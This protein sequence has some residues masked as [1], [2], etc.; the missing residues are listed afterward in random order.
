MLLLSA[1]VFG[2]FERVPT[3]AAVVDDPYLFSVFEKW[4][5]D[6]GRVYGSLNEKLQRFGVFKDNFHFIE[7]MK[8]Q[9]GLAYTVGLSKFA[10]L[11]NK[12]FLQRCATYRTP[13]ETK[14]T[15]PFRY[16]NLTVIP[17]SLHWRNLAAVTPIKDQGNCGELVTMEVE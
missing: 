2:L 3:S 11:T 5:S 6:H 16:A 17:S 7:S 1:L 10:D 14:A 4:V 8:N 15:T 12:E 9:S 13:S